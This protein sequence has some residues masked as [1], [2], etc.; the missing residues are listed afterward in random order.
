MTSPVMDDDLE[1]EVGDPDARVALAARCRADVPEA[2][3]ERE[4]RAFD[5]LLERGSLDGRRHHV[6]ERG[7]ALELGELEHR[8]EAADDG[9]HEVG[10]DVLGVVELDPG[11]IAGVATDVGDDEA[12]LLGRT[13]HHEAPH[14]A[15]ATIAG[16]TRDCKSRGRA[17]DPGDARAVARCGP[18][19][20]GPSR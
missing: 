7:V 6:G 16:P 5:R 14:I 11:E 10:E 18:K 12:R 1:V 19:R 20:G 8:P 9:R 3:L 4:V 15:P 13:G 2:A 17:G